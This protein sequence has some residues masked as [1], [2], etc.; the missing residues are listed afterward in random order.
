MVAHIETVLISTKH[1]KTSPKMGSEFRS[2]GLGIFPQTLCALKSCGKGKAPCVYLRCSPARAASSLTL[3][4]KT[5][6]HFP[7]PTEVSHETVAG[8]PLFR[9]CVLVCAPCPC[10]DQGAFYVAG[11]RESSHLS[12]LG[13]RNPRWAQGILD[14]LQN[15]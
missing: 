9:I 12:F 2:Q 14:V 5:F 10:L 4:S 11:A 8:R 3:T 15:V 1:S 7:V 6:V 13:I